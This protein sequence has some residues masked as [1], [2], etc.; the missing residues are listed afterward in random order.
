MEPNRSHHTRH[1]VRLPS[2][3][4]IE[5]V[6]RDRN[7]A[8]APAGSGAGAPAAPTAPDNACV[9]DPL[10]VCFH[11]AGDLVYPLDWIEEGPRHWRIVLRCPECESRREGVFEQA[12][13]EQLDEQLD[14]AAG[15]LLG[16]LQQLT[17][18]NM[19]DE[20]EFFVRALDADLIVPSDF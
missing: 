12:T 15:A 10:H 4:Q 9:P 13:V 19:K 1:R 5:V 2:G 6:Y 17:Q 8:A 14:R 7:Q 3:K 16:D 18:A 20:V 11:C